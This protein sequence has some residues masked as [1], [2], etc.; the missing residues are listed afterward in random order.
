MLEKW[1]WLEHIP[2]SHNNARFGSP[3]K[4]NLLSTVRHPAYS[5]NQKPF[6]F[7]SNTI[8]NLSSSQVNT[9]LV[10]FY[11]SVLYSCLNL[12]L[13]YAL[14]SK[15]WCNHTNWSDGQNLDRYP[16]F[17]THWCKSFNYFLCFKG[18]SLSLHR[19]INTYISYDYHRWNFL[20]YHFF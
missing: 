3:W 16:S 17:F 5:L 19:K 18:H 4:Y 14:S 7:S 2:N 9:K 1:T 6:Y 13:L 10:G 20:I 12:L 15:A 11:S 8:H